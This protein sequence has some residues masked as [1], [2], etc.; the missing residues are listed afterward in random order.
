MLSLTNVFLYTFINLPISFMLIFLSTIRCK[1]MRCKQ[2]NSILK[3]RNVSE[4]SKVFNFHS[5][6]AILNCYKAL[7]WEIK[8]GGWGHCH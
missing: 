3:Q 5:Y 4:K 1:L 8:L 2:Q 6:C 7:R